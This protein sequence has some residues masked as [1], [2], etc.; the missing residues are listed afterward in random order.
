MCCSQMCQQVVFHWKFFGAKVTGEN[1]ASVSLVM[2]FKVVFG[3]VRPVADVALV[4]ATEDVR[5]DVV[6]QTASGSNF[7]G[8][9]SAGEISFTSQDRR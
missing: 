8:T 6:K 2:G 3:G 9:Q 1:V 5:L 4:G 7:F